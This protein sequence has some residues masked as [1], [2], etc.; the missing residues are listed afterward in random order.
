MGHEVV[1]ANGIDIWTDRV[2]KREDPTILLVTGALGQ[3]AVWHYTFIEMLSERG[4]QVIRY[5]QRDSGGSSRIP[6]DQTYTIEDLADDAAG[7]LDAFGIAHAHVA[8]VSAGGVFAQA[9]T[10]RHPSK[11]LSLVSLMGTSGDFRTDPLIDGPIDDNAWSR[12]AG[13]PGTREEQIAATLEKFHSHLSGPRFALND[14]Y[15]RDIATSL[16]GPAPRLREALLEGLP[17][18]TDLARTIRVPMLA[19]HGTADPLIRYSNAF[20]TVRAIPGTRLVPVEGMGHDM[21]S[22][23]FWPALIDLMV[24]HAETAPPWWVRDGLA[25]D[26]AAARRSG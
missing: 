16:I 10:A 19:I 24:H 2:G 12:E 25:S 5:D 9:L 15:L 13:P 7:V 20:S 6:K 18:L 26:P 22:P 1:K 3:A 23:R 11:V 21:V 14:D 17:R 8:G 4:F